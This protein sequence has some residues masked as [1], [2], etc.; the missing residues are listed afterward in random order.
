MKS[1]GPVVSENVC[2]G[3]LILAVGLVAVACNSERPNNAPSKK[4]PA[5]YVLPSEFFLRSTVAR[6]PEGEVYIEGTTNLPDGL[7]FNVDVIP[8]IGREPKPADYLRG[9]LSLDKG[10]VTVR[11]GKFRSPG[12]MVW[13]PNPHF[14]RGHPVETGNAKYIRVP[15]PPSKKRVHFTAHFISSDPASGGQTSEVYKLIGN[16]GKK[17]TGPLFKQTDSDVIDSDKELDYFQLVE[18]PPLTPEAEAIN[19]VK[20]AVLTVPGYG[21]SSTDIG[22]NVEY[23]MKGYALLA[24]MPN[25]HPEGK[26]WSA[27][28]TGDRTY[29]VS[30]DFITDDEEGEH[31]AVWSANLATRK[32]NYVNMAA[33]YMSWTPNY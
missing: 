22:Q 33:K 25:F 31:Q 19:L 16:G 30:F 24:K 27:R 32:V 28:L 9:D 26:G 1:V 13:F 20:R 14:D 10:V 2:M 11:S 3:L 12:L 15:F 29:A 18:L 4:E 5:S 23:N 8:L 17:L 7:I 6:G 21:K